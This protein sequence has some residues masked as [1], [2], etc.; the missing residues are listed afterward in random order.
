MMVDDDLLL[1][2]MYDPVQYTDKSHFPD[3]FQLDKTWDTVLVNY[4]LLTYY[5]LEDL[6]DNWGSTGA[7]SKLILTHWHKLTTI[8]HLIGGHLLRAR[9]PSLSG[10]FLTDKRLQAFITLPLPHHIV[11]GNDMDTADISAC[12][13]AFMLNLADELPYALRQRFSLCFPA[14]MRIPSLVASVTPD[15]INLLQMAI[16]YANNFCI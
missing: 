11:P 1:R 14:H 5:K 12:G 2:V 9:M 7:V 16:H 3:S 6:P 13:A 10:A 15:H 8:A 4:W